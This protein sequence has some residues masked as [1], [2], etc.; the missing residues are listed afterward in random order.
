MSR[1]KKAI[2]S[3]KS[4]NNCA[5]SVLSTYADLFP[6]DQNYVVSLASG[7][8]AGMGRLQETCGAVTGS[9]M[10]LGLYNGTKYSNNEKRKEATNQLIQAFSKDFTAEFGTLRCK[11][12]I[13]CD[14]NTAQGQ[15]EF[16]ERKL[17][18]NVCQKCI[19]SAVKL[20]NQLITSTKIK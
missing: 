4:G 13:N 1:E 2:Q 18:E 15:K 11:T 17:N 6:F 8:G 16:K 7:F 9:F 14:L 10:V 20:T 19:S 5:Q 3:F 12:L